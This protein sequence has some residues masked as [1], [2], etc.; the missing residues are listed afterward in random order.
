MADFILQILSRTPVWVWVLFIALVALGVMQNQARSVSGSR[1]FAL[2]IAM[3][4]Y[5][6]F[7]ALSA[8]GPQP[9]ALISWGAAVLL[10][11]FL[12]RF[13]KRP[14]DVRYSKTTG[15]F[16]IPGS[17]APLTL[18]MTIFFIRYIATV[19]LVIDATLKQ[20]IAFASIISLLTGMMSGIFLARALRVLGSK[21]RL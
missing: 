17:W 21:K 14:A 18:M 3:L 10:A 11:V 16:A 19:A 7:G 5:S 8:F 4:G 2:P 6:L 1:L 9:A 12:G 20:S 13:L 15:Q